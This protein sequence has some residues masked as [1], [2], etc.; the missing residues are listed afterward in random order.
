MTTKST[1]RHLHLAVAFGLTLAVGLPACGG[2]YS[3]EDLDFIGV[4]PDRGDLQARPP[5][6]HAL[7]AADA[8]EYLLITRDVVVTFNTMA[9]KLTGL[10]DFVRAHPPTSREGD[11]RIWG[12]FP[13][14]TARGW[15]LRM[16]MTRGREAGAKGGFR[17]FH[18]LQVRAVGTPT[19]I[20]LMSGTFAPGAG[21][22]GGNGLLSLVVGEARAAGYPVADLRELESLQIAYERSSFPVRLDMIIEKVAG[23]ATPGATYKYSEDAD[24]TGAM[25]F[26]WRQIEPGRTYTAS[27]DSRWLPTGPGR[28]DGRLLEV[29]GFPL[30]NA[31]ATDCWGADGRPTYRR[32]DWDMDPA[33]RLVGSP[34]T[35][36]FPPL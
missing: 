22:S 13:H 31:H 19:W 16:R 1:R 28:A 21:A 3:N 9:D 6:Q 24:G 27:I 33:R 15:E 14:E 18:E 25:S 20:R 12:P 36:V 30:P 26:V 8:A 5:A 34:D 23:S 35:C 7:T 10:V 29:N 11:V 32:R 17:F 2:N 4:A